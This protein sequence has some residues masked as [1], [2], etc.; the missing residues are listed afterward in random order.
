VFFSPLRTSLLHLAPTIGAAPDAVRLHRLRSFRSEPR[1]LFFPRLGGPLPAWRVCSPSPL[2]VARRA[3]LIP[4]RRGPGPTRL[5]CPPAR[6][7][8]ARSPGH[9]APCPG[10]AP[11]RSP[12]PS[13]ARPPAS[14]HGRAPPR[15]GP[16]SPQLA[17]RARACA[18]PRRPPARLS[19]L[20]VLA[21][22]GLELGRCASGARPELG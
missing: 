18:S 11:T 10:A 3:R 5:R 21:A 14:A 12:S 20:P 6:L 7:P 22:H 17:A 15:R 19:L 16:P 1:P 9:G 4:A 13:P 2:A 8:L